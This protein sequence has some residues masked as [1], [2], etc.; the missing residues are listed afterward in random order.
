MGKIHAMSDGNS[1]M[2]KKK[3]QK[4]KSEETESPFEV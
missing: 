1:I 4:G 2:E 3:A